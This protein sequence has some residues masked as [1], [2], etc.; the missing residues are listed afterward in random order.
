MGT[1]VFTAMDFLFY[2]TWNGVLCFVL[3]FF[4]LSHG[5]LRESVFA[6]FIF[7]SGRAVD[8]SLQQAGRFGV[9][10]LLF[11][12]YLYSFHLF[13]FFLKV[14]FSSFSSFSH[15]RTFSFRRVRERRWCLV[16]CYLLDLRCV[17]FSM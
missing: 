13:F 16:F 4:V 3:Q 6:S 15:H 17:D 2:Y 10:L 11:G 12:R 7:Y 8:R 14:S 9:L 1:V 5:V